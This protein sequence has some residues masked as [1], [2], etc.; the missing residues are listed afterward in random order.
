MAFVCVLK[1][2]KDGGHYIGLTDD[3][4]KRVSKHNAGYIQST[5]SRRPFVLIHAEEF[6]NRVDAAKREK[7]LKSGAG[8]KVLGLLLSRQG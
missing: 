6:E 8:R 5:T 3:V 4:S 2:I 7:F 1:S